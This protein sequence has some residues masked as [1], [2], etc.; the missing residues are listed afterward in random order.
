MKSPIFWDF[1]YEWVQIKNAPGEEHFDGIYLNRIT[2][3]QP[4]LVLPHHIF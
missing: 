1:F 2:V 3:Q 4:F